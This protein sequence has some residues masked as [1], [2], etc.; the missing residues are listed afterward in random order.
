[1]SLFGLAFSN[2]K[3]SVHQYASLILALAFSIFIFFNFQNVIY[4]DSMDV[5][6]NFNK[7]YIDMVVQ[8]ATVVFTVFLF[9]FIWYATNVFL[10]QRKKEIGIFIFMGLDNVRIGKMYAVEAVLTGLSALILGLAS[11]VCFSKLFQMLLLKLSEIS[12]DVEFSFSVPTILITTV[13]FVVV[14][15]FMVLKGYR[16]IVKSSV[17][18]M[19]SGAKQK[20]MKKEPFLLTMT[21][22]VL[23]IVTLGAG[24]FCALKTGAESTM[25]FALGAVILVIVGTYLLFGGLIPFFIGRLAK[26]KHYLYQKQRNLWVNNLAFRVKKNYRTYAMVTILMICSVTVLAVSIALKQRYERMTHF[27][28]TYT[29][30]VLSNHEWDADEIKAGISKT[31]EVSYHSEISFLMLNPEAVDTKYKFGTY[32][33]V[34]YSQIR[35]GAEAAGL[36]FAYEEPEDH[37]TVELTHEI[38]LS[39]VNEEAHPTIQIQDKT[40]D[41]LASD[42][43]PFMG[44][45]QRN[46][47]AYMVSDAEYERLKPLGEI[48]HS[49]HYKIKDPQ[50]YEQSRSYLQTLVEQ[51]EDLDARMTGVNIISPENNEEAWIRVMYSL[52]VFMFVTFILAG[53]SII[54]IKLNN[55]AYED[56]ER[57]AILQKLG[58]SK[59]TLYQSM[60]H[61]IRFTYYCPFV[62]MGITSF[63][64]VK[65]LGNAMKED[66]IRVNLYSAIGIFLIFT[67][68]CMISTRVFR[69]KVLEK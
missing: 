25:G 18:E 20:E 44:E 27:R 69:K 37:E 46:L 56:R 64:A 12:V 49:Y 57:Y 61:E 14:F 58:I 3:R 42:S 45:L 65:A 9:F 23:G 54:F 28:N 48:W 7:S 4:S 15:G 33:V 63:F 8:A 22:V 68:I 5:L 24:Y 52:C 59:D 35:E 11:G 17:L 60:K 1:M 32:V 51:G 38:L 10:N 36:P 47:S 13:M 31:N 39:F 16:T 2:F 29:Y 34:P 26:N 53:G 66:L 67:L 30:Q 21:K 40:Y 62:L 19:L 43:T 41:I 55:E 6:K 50:N